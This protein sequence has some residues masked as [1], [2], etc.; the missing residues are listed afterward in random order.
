MFVD[1]MFRQVSNYLLALA[2]GTFVLGM[3]G[4]VL[5][6]LLPDVAN[7]LSVSVSTAGQLT[8]IFTVTYAVGSPVIAAVTGP[9]DRRTVLRAGM[10]LFLLGLA[11]QALGPTYVVVAAGRFLAALGAAA[12]Q[13]TAYAVAGLLAREETRGRDLAVIAAG[14]ATATV[15]GLPF[16]VFVGEHVGWRGAT[17]LIAALA[18]VAA[19]LAG[20]VPSVHAPVA[21]LR[22]RA[23]VLIRP[24]VLVV[25]LNAAL[26][27]G[28]MYLVLGYLP[29]LLTTTGGN[30]VVLALVVAGMGQ[31]AGNRVVGRLVDAHGPV[32]VALAGTCAA[33]I[34]YASLAV[35][36]GWDVGVIGV[37]LLLGA[38]LSLTFPPQQNRV[39]RIAPD[40]APVALGLVGAALY[41][42][43][44]VGSSLGGAVLAAWGPPALPIAAAALSALSALLLW[45]LA[46]ERRLQA[47]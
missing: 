21:S 18:V 1:M 23:G 47:T 14:A 25:V 4:F 36:R 11:T 45:G 2:A 17:W 5:S 38:C 28:P 39:F 13:A 15:A 19:L 32:P 44:T 46:P 20:A 12:F 34:V 31:L 40:V 3:D 33:V 42:G 22:T 30:R 7:D 27:T 37:L 10:L 26:V 29:M 6:G 35:V 24:A 9:L 8:T 43:G 16:G 41:A